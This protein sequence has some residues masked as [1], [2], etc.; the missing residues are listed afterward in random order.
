MR[1]VFVGE[2]IEEAVDSVS[3]AAFQKGISLDV[4]LEL[5]EAQVEGDRERLK[6]AIGN[7]ISNAV[8]FTQ[9]GGRINVTGCACDG[10]IRCV[11]RDNGPGISPEFLPH[12]FEQYKQSEVAS[13]R[14]FGGLGLGLTIAHHVVKLHNGSIEAASAGA[15][16]GSTFTIHLPAIS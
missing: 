9:S 13:T 15:G 10:E 2:L 5:G 14:H 3:V 6:L 11:V 1:P 7:V 16:G 8:K 4:D 12:V